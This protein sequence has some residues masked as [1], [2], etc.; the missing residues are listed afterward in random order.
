MEALTLTPIQRGNN[1]HQF[2]LVS[3]EPTPEIEPSQGK[4]FILANTVPF[5]LREMEQEHIIPV[6][7]KDNEPLISHVV[8]VKGVD[9]V[10]DN[11]YSEI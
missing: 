1:N 3:F 4:A 7:A 6:F 2:P 8:F 11:V 10:V 9:Q 5:A